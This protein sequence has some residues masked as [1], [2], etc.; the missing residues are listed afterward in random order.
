MYWALFLVSAF[1]SGPD[2]GESEYI[3]VDTFENR[4]ECEVARETWLRQ[5]GIPRDVLKLECLRVDER[6]K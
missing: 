6:W 1:I 3:H 5:H 2:L 4:L